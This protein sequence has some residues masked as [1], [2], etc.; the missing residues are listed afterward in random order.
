MTRAELKKCGNDYD[1]PAGG[2]K[3]LPRNSISYAPLEPCENQHFGERHKALALRQRLTLLRRS[4]HFV[5][6]SSYLDGLAEQIIAP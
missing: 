1:R 4:R 2:C 3:F 6:R 5:S